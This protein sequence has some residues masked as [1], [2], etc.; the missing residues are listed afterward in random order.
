MSESVDLPSKL[1]PNPVLLNIK[2]SRKQAKTKSTFKIRKLIV[3]SL[4]NEEQE[5]TKNK[6]WKNKC[7][8]LR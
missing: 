3:L 8:Y 6:E 4:K 2:I 5:V 1:M 7:L